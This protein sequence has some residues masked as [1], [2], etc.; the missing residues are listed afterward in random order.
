MS[1]IAA[2][3]K[4]RNNSDITSASLGLEFP[5]IRPPDVPLY[6][7][8]L[9]AI[10]QG[11]WT[12][13][14]YY[15]ERNSVTALKIANAMRCSVSTIHDF[16]WERFEN[17]FGGRHKF[18][19]AYANFSYSKT[20]KEAA[21]AFSELYLKYKFG[22]STAGELSER[23]LDIANRICIGIGESAALAEIAK[24]DMDSAQ[25]IS[26]LVGSPIGFSGYAVISDFCLDRTMYE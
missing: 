20:A 7:C 19:K 6:N 13:I 9:A 4:T 2:L 23:D 10:E 15:S 5:A 16:D 1:E 14:S 21:K 18:F 22:E 12:V 11:I 3:N 24:L 25:T 17:V 26:A 8:A